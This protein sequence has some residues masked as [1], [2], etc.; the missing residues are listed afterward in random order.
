MVSAAQIK[1]LRDQTGISMSQC[2][3][4][5]ETAGGDLA[6]ALEV[7]RS[8]GAAIAEKKAGRDL[9]A[10]R[11]GSYFHTANT[12]GVM[13]EVACET[14]FVAKTADFQ[15]LAD[16]LAMH[17]AGFN[18]ADLA[19]LLTQPYL[20]DATRTITQVVNEAIQKLGERIEI[21]RFARFQVC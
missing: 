20:K 16:D 11:I 14:D 5:L 7:L 12:I 13:V 3:Q 1:E 10:G 21:I 15:K 19:E 8:Q 4:A 17:I 18:P 2:K 9:G 6:K